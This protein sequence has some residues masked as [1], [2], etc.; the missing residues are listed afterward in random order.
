VCAQN[1]EF[2][3]ATGLPGITF[4][5]AKFDGI[6]GMAYRTISVD[7]LNPVFNTMLEQGAIS[8][9]VFSFWLDRC[10]CVCENKCV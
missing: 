2:A 5:A 10:V 6:L 1:Q 7:N 8:Q 4:V 9:P 3:E